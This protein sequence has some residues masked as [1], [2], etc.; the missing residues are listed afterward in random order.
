MA[1]AGWKG[2]MLSGGD[3]LGTLRSQE[4]PRKLRNPFNY[5]KKNVPIYR[6]S[7]LDSQSIKTS[8]DF[9]KIPSVNEDQLSKYP[10]DFRAENLSIYRISLSGG[11]S[12]K[13]KM[14]FRTYE[15]HLASCEIAAEKLRISRVGP[16]RSVAVPQPFNIVYR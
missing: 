11:S 15:D 14:I 16:K 12:Q 6:Q 7:Q 5:A 4:I 2:I 3:Q 10:I 9:Q 1:N 13:R 8:G